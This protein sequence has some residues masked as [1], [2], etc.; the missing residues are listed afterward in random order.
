MKDFIDSLL[1]II[2]T[3]KEP[4]YG[5]KTFCSL[6]KSLENES[7]SSLNLFV[8]DNSPISLIS[9]DY[10][11]HNKQF[12]V[13]YFH[14][15]LNSGLGVA[16]NNGAKVAG[17]LG[18]KWLLLLDQDTDFPDDVLSKYFEA[19]MANQ[20]IDIFAPTLFS[21]KGELISPSKYKFRRGSKLS[22]IPRGTTSLTGITPINSGILL[23]LS[24]FNSVGGYNEKIR[25]DFS[26]HAFI[27]KIRTIRKDFYVIPCYIKHNL[28]SNKLQN[29]EKEIIRFGFFCEGAKNA[30]KD[31]YS[32]VNYFI[33]NA[34]RAFKLSFVF[35]NFKFFR[36]LFKS[37]FC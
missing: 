30:A 17:D 4:Y 22:F 3:Y 33:I 13:N 31:T 15:S 6:L 34:L 5:C 26:D 25:L 11:T 2:V 35:K 9:N 32:E 8:Y 23:K 18:K 14:D 16:Y 28:S 1:I 7:N 37:W 27:D 19:V 12:K 21:P 29:F 24:L 36:V 10:N 20:S